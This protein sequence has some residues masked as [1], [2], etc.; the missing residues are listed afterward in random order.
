M[1]FYIAENAKLSRFSWMSVMAVSLRTSIVKRE[2]HGAQKVVNVQGNLRAEVEGDQ[3]DRGCG[4]TGMV[5]EL[6]DELFER[7]ER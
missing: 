2:V 7:A 1:T 5:P 4:R 6:G 3:G